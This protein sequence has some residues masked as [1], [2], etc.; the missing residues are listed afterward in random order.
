MT[1]VGSTRARADD[2]VCHRAYVETQ[3]LQRTAHFQAARREAV[4]CGQDTCSETV[5][6]QCT[7]WL[8]NIERALPTLVIDARD[9]SG[10]TLAAVR[11]EANG[12]LLAERLNGRALELDPGEYV[13]RFRHDGQVVDQRTLIRESEKYRTIAVRFGDPPGSAPALPSNEPLTATMSSGPDTTHAMASSTLGKPPRAVPW[14]SGGAPELEEAAS[15]P[16]ASYLLG[17]L[18]LASLTASAA[19]ALSGYASE[20]RLRRT[21]AGACE[22]ERVDAVRT[23]YLVADAALGVSIACLGAA[24]AVWIWTP[25]ESSASGGLS[26]GPHR[27]AFEGEF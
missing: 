20:R 25:R 11:V 13:L 27:I 24:A 14:P 6:S 9:G 8:E 7:T 5:R 23:Q 21:C 26:L 16:M 4:A 12:D 2:T 22:G 3:R 19:V 10:A 18:G 15:I 1:S 17:G